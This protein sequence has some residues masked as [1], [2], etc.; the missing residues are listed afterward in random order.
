MSDETVQVEGLRQLV[1][2]LKAAEV[3]LDDLKDANNAAGRIVL[4][5][6]RPRT[7][8]RTGALAA[9]GRANRAA[10][11][12]NVVFGTARVPYGPPIHWGWAARHIK[13]QPWVTTAAQATQGD[14]VAAYERDIQRVLDSVKGDD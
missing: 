10:G 3:D 5:A 8:T 9:S 12:A 7:P 13:A 14:W 11:K 2:T 4:D 1:R 6:A